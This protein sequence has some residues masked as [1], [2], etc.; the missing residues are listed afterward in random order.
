MDKV[1]EDSESFAATYLDGTFVYS[2]TWE[3]NLQ[4]LREVLQHLHKAG[5]TVQP[6]KCTLAKK[7]VRYLGYLLGFGVIRPQKD[8]A[9]SAGLPSSAAPSHKSSPSMDSRG[10]TE[11]LS[12]IRHNHIPTQWWCY[13][14]LH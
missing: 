7:E 12:P 10:G 13:W 5:L 9:S 8:S 11:D 3:N 6:K 14:N 1:L 4:H 2:R